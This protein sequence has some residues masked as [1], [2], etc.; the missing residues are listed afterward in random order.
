MTWTTTLP[1][2]PGWYWW[3]N[4][5]NSPTIYKVEVWHGDVWVQTHGTVTHRVAQFTGEWA[6]PIAQPKEPA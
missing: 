2:T 4:P 3:R 1:M 5:W 6:G